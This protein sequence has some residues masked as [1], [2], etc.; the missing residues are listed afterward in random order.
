MTAIA[1]TRPDLKR[2][3]FLASFLIIL[4][5]PGPSYATPAAPEVLPADQV[6][7]VEGRAGGPHHLEVLFRIADGTYLYRHKV[8]FE[9]QPP[10]IQPG[11]F[12]LPAG[13]PKEDPVFGRIEIFRQAL[14]VR[15]P[16]SLLPRKRGTSP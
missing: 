5:F 11:D 12:K 8:K 16:I 14:Q 2:R 1:P 6:F 7:Q 3:F 15:I 4:F 9:I 13:Q 10:E